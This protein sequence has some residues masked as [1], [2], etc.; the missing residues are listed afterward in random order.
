[1]RPL[2]LS[3]LV[4]QGT[5]FC[6]IDC[7]YCYLPERNKRNVMTE[8]V[9]DAVIRRVA[10][11]PHVSNRVTVLWHV[12]EPLTAGVNYFR[13]AFERTKALRNAEYSHTIQTN[14]T[15]ITNEFCRLFKEYG[16]QI[17]VSIDGPQDMHDANRIRR[18]GTGTFEAAMRGVALLREHS[19]PFTIITVITEASFERLPELFAFYDANNLR[20]VAFNIEEIEGANTATSLAARTDAEMQRFWRQAFDLSAKHHIALR[21]IDSMLPRLLG[22]H[23][24]NSQTAPGDHITIAHNGNFSTY[25][26]EIAGQKHPVF[27]E[28]FIGN[29]LST[30]FQNAFEGPKNHAI[31][32]EIEKGIE[33]CRQSCPYFNVCKGGQPS[34]KLS[35]TGSFAIAE[36]EHCRRYLKIRAEAFLGILEYEAARLSLARAT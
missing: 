36:T 4:L 12:G 19:I 1:M 10:E 30:S 28:L 29:V 14:G 18:N 8:E 13:N 15:L 3:L 35:E 33:H 32:A 9:L 7:R 34:N 2:P 22:Q 31:G 11:H 5:Q 6:N 20:H 25:S 23:V 16:V 26:P 27:G 21:E 17:G 24:I